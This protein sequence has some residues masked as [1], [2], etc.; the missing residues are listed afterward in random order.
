MLSV[1]FFPRLNRLAERESLRPDWGRAWRCT[2]AF[3]VPLLLAVAGRLPVEM[4]FAAVAA[5][6]IALVDVRGGYTLRFTLLLAMSAVMAAAA[7]LGALTGHPLGLAL[8]ATAVVAGGTGLWRHLSSEYGPSLSTASFLL[9][10]I[11]LA[12][13]GGTAAAAHHFGAALLGGIWGVALQVALWPIRPQHPLR[14][15]VAESWIAVSDLFAAIA[16]PPREAVAERAGAIRAAEAAL[17]TALDKTQAALA[18]SRPGHPH[19]VAAR[20]DQLNLAASRLAT[21]VVA[22][23]SAAEALSDEPGFA[24]LAPSFAPALTA[25][26]NTARTVAL[27]VVSRQP[28]HLATAEVRRQ[29]LHN[30]LRV[31]QARLAAQT[32]GSAAWAQLIAVL[33]QIEAYLP[34]VSEALRATIERADERSAVS[35][36]LFDLQTLTL[37][38]LAAALNLSWRFERALILYTFRLAALTV[39]GVWVFKTHSLPH[40]YWLPFTMVV[41]LQ[42]DYGS[43]RQKA[44][45]RLLG[46][47][48]GSIFASLLLWLNLPFAVLMAGTALMSFLFGYFI[49]RNYGVAVIFITLFVVLLTE[50]NSPVTLALTAERLGC[51]VAGGGLALLAALVFWPVWERDHFWPILARAV[52]AN[53]EYLRVVLDRL[54][55]GEAYDPE[56]SHAKRRAEMA[57]SAVF[58]SLQRMS[59]DPKNRQDDRLKAAAALANGNQRLTRTLNLMAL[60][61]GQGGAVSAPELAQFSD[62]AVAAL[63][64]LAEVLGQPAADR[65]PLA[66][67]RAGLDGLKLPQLEDSAAA[68]RQEWAFA[69]VARASTELSAMLLAAEERPL[70]AEPAP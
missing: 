15:A 48:I 68:T 46:T 29:R 17:Q 31:L 51:T 53:R 2:F 8:A 19:P 13:P 41:V 26:T 7:G 64:E 20:L 6:N 57:N 47:L 39:A 18:A 11:A 61:L 55:Q 58:S 45:Q 70:G 14:V 66:Q 60:H 62:R 22:F 49:K 37:R 50:A 56:V 16:L 3:M 67:A 36:E 44:A 59:G 52:H 43:T 69:Q 54:R 42:P 23:N 24:A 28:A 38:P 27:A 40:G 65:A 33:G 9:F 30:L 32:D 1:P 12:L 21:R 10:L 4:I 34:I 63:A 25:L 35:L 5:Q